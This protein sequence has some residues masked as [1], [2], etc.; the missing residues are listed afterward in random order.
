MREFKQVSREVL[1]TEGFPKP[2]ADLTEGVMLS[3]PEEQEQVLFDFVDLWNEEKELVGRIKTCKSNLAT[4]DCD[5]EISVG[6][7]TRKPR[8]ELKE[9]QTKMT[10]LLDRALDLGMGGLNI[11]QKN[12]SIFNVK[13]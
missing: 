13:P 8:A 12:C 5:D 1:K 4:V 3:L 9:V 2:P 11:I 10:A 6:F 7:L